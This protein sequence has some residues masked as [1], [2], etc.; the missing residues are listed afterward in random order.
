MSLITNN[1]NTLSE[2]L[3]YEVSEHEACEDEQNLGTIQDDA[4][5]RKAG[6]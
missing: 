5:K 1:I 3:D 4:A 2:S 6:D